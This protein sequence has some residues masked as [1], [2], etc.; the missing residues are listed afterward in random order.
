MFFLKKVLFKDLLVKRKFGRLCLADYVSVVT[1]TIA[2]KSV[3]TG[4]PVCYHF[5]QRPIC[6]GEMAEVPRKICRI[7]FRLENSLGCSP[8]GVWGG[9][10][11]LT[12]NTKEQTYW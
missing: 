2:T 4:K 8:V 5:Q 11:D 3:I 10:D 9:L 6:D 12:T 1:F 7:S